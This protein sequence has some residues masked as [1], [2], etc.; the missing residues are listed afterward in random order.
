MQPRLERLRERVNM[1]SNHHQKFIRTIERYG[2]ELIDRLESMGRIEDVHLWKNAY[3]LSEEMDVVISIATDEK[4][5]CRFLG[6]YYAFQILHLNLR[7]IDVMMLNLTREDD[8][9]AVYKRFM[10]TFGHE[11]RVL[12]STY[13]MKLL[14]LF[15]E[16]KEHPEFVICSVGS[17][18]HQDDLDIGI[19]DDGTGRR[20]VLNLG[21]GKLRH[22]MLKF[23][24]E[25][26]MY[27]SEHVGEQNY[28]ASID[29]YKKLLAPKIGDFVIISEML[30]A[31]PILGNSQLFK[32][33]ERKVTRRYYFQNTRNNLYHEG[34]LRGILG[35]VRSLIIRQ[36]SDHALNPK[37]D[38]LRMLLGMILVGRTVFRIYHGH[39][40]QV[41]EELCLRNPERKD[42][43]D[44]LEESVTFIEAFRHVYQLFVA[45][46]EEIPLDDPTIQDQLALVA[47]T[48]GYRDVGAVKAWDHLLIHYHEK[49]EMAKIASAKMLNQI[50]EHLKLVSRFTPLINHASVQPLKRQH[51]INLAV[52]FLRH[53]VFFTGAKFWD[54][55]LETIA[56]PGNLALQNFV[57]DIQTLP[58]RI[59]NRIIHMF[60]EIVPKATYAMLYFMVRLYENRRRLNCDEL[61]EELSNSFLDHLA[62]YPEHTLRIAKIFNHFPKLINDYLLTLHG[63]QKQKFLDL[64]NG[65]LW[66][67]EDNLAK[68]GLVHLCGLHFSN[69]LYFKRFF[70]RVINN[71]PEYIQ[72]LKDSNALQQI[73]KGFLGNIDSLPTYKE[74]KKQLGNFYD[75]EF[76]RLGL[77]TLKG[78][79][80]RI[81]NVEFTE[82][83]DIYIQMLFDICK[84]Q[85]DEEIGTTIH[86][87]DLF[88]IFT[89]GGHAREQ[90][91]DDD[92]DILIVLN[93][94]DE[95]VVKYMNRIVTAMNAEIIKRGTM[96]HY[97][98]ADH[99]GRY[100]T[101]VDEL[102]EFFKEPSD[103]SFIDKS[104]IL[105][106][107]MIVGS[108][109]FERQFEERIIR[110]HIYDQ[111]ETYIKHM[112]EEMHSRHQDKRNLHESIKN[113]KEAV[114]G[115]RDIETILLIYKARY[116][117]REPINRRLLTHLIELV[118]QHAKHL[119]ALDD[120][121]SFL[122]HL[123]DL[124]RLTVSAGDKINESYLGPAATIMGFHSSS[125][126]SA[127]KQLVDRFHQ[128]ML[129]VAMRINFIVNDIEGNGV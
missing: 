61:F 8:R 14:N 66:S 39:R 90:A 49:V 82:F 84:Q 110:P 2:E 5:K 89:A 72:Y 120:A 100:I 65:D 74:K 58:P 41:L 123:R 17:L 50:T 128:T 30:T 16:G 27:L 9:I 54:D 102:D 40:W 10:L 42:I 73:A 35:E 79:P 56:T 59:R 107:R 91:F 78:V 3:N 45:Q 92:Y 125:S 77:E 70:V 113:V 38:G 69:S 62:D 116:Q 23:A 124:Y 22:E 7:S 4:E 101:L 99:F 112:I 121:F 71:Y 81:I 86:T 108:S 18:A 119:Q 44:Q 6:C 104:Q 97:R 28:S 1:L 24:T 127:Q 55:L 103:H 60:G 53:S 34:F 25:M 13:M 64:L 20:D 83:S 21:I 88:A 76:L 67:R 46:E 115:L 52:E 106:S 26:H 114:G 129:H 19:I 96:P 80:I 63:E 11:F 105:G 93:N 12:T 87:K 85:V 32:Q 117:L 33:F 122:K 47:R 98:F 37:D 57:H 95:D 109:K 68:D 29:E 118:P 126:A 15:F 36:M 51:D 48:L 43:Y 94:N 31:F 75:L 111:S